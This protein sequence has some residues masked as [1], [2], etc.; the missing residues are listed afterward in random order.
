MADAGR[1]GL[2][3]SPGS[4]PHPPLV[5]S[6]HGDPSPPQRL[7]EMPNHRKMRAKSVPKGTAPEERSPQQ[8]KLMK[9]KMSA[10][11]DGKRKEVSSV[12][13]FH[14]VPWGE[15]DVM[16]GINVM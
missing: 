7:T 14:S 1:A 15:D 2:E 5:S 8:R 4:G 11:T 16:R 6:K 13:F 9:R 12:I 10:M 3:R